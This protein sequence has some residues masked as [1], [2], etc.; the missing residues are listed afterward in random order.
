M[1][2]SWRRRGHGGIS[3]YPAALTPVAIR[4]FT[5]TV[6]RLSRP[7]APRISVSIH[8]NVRADNQWPMPEGLHDLIQ[9]CRHRG[10]LRL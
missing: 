8:T 7:P 4:Q 6:R 5:L 1:P 9:L 10:H 2:E 3:R